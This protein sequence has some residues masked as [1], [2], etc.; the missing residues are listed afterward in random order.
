MKQLEG[1]IT[2]QY[3]ANHK[4]VVICCVTQSYNMFPL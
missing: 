3:L 1:L 4:E 2:D